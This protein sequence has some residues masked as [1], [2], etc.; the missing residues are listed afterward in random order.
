MAGAP[1]DKPLMDIPQP[2]PQPQPRPTIGLAHILKAATALGALGANAQSGPKLLAMLCNPDSKSRVVAQWVDQDP[3]ISARVLRVA[4]SPYYGQTRSITT[5]ERALLLLGLD[6][7]RGIAAA[8]CLDRTLSRRGALAV[9]DMHAV[10]QHSLATAVAADLLARTCRPAL[11]GEAFIGGLLHNFGVAV[12]AHVDAPGVAAMLERRRHEA[13]SGIRQLEAEYAAVGHEECVAAIFDSWRLPDSLVMAARHHHDPAAAPE[14][15]RDLA[16][17]LNLAAHVGLAGGYTFGL[18][19]VPGEP[20][21][22]AL[23]RL[24]LV[25]EDLLPLVQ[26]VPMRVTELR[27]ALT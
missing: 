25:E 24:G 7:V 15:Y 11:S 21:A 4:N 20:H 2:Q 3:V 6:A 12:Q 22:Q 5:V 9:L 13:G 14:A 23:V 27:R 18:A 26:E 16:A 10:M 19:P 17:T 8:A 1:A